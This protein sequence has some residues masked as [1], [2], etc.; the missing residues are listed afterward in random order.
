MQGPRRHRHHGS[1]RSVLGVALVVSSMTAH[2]EAK[3]AG[4]DGQAHARLSFQVVIPP[5]M[6]L[7]VTAA[8]NG[9]AS[10]EAHGNQG[11]TL[12]IKA[13]DTRGERREAWVYTALAL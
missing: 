1:P 12:V 6:A 13:R 2:A 8:L 4:Q 7:N 11:T 3:L 9:H 10:A 5:R